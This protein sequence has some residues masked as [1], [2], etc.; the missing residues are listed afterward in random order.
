MTL[1]RY[2]PLCLVLMGF[3]PGAMQIW[4]VWQ[5]EPDGLSAVTGKSPAWDFTNL[6][7]GGVLAA[8]GRVGMIFDFP[9]YADWLRAILGPRA[10]DH[11]WSYPPSMLLL[12]VPLSR[13]AH[14]GCRSRRAHGADRVPHLPR[15]ALRIFLRHG[16]VLRRRGVVD[17]ARRLA[18]F[19]R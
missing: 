1:R 9:A 15:H 10:E 4:S 5:F 8:S 18:G 16:G 13:L 12:G 3:V 14:G 17:G 19:D 11:E 7:A 6:W 2:R